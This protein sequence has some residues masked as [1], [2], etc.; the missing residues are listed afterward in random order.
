[1]CQLDGIHSSLYS[2]R[3][4]FGSRQ[5]QKKN[6]KKVKAERCVART[7]I[8]SIYLVACILGKLSS[9]LLKRF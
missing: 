7:I 4:R 8:A 3:V 5:S 2:R 1:M 9:L 6:L